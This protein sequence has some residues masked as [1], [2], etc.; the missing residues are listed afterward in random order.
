[1]TTSNDAKDANNA[2]NA[3]D[4][5]SASDASNASD[6]TGAK[7]ASGHFDPALLADLKA[8]QIAFFQ[9][10]LVSAK[11]EEDWRSRAA[12]VYAELL[13]TPLGQ[14]ADAAAIADALDAALSADAVKSAFRPLADAVLT[15]AAS[16]IRSQRARVG[17]YIPD[18]SLAKI[19]RLLERP[20]LF[21][22]RL[23]RQVVEQEAVEEVMR[24]VLYA[25]LKEFSEKV[26]PFFAEWGLPALLGKLM[27]FGF[28]GVKKALDGVRAEFDRRL[29][30]ELRKFLPGVTRRGLRQ[31]AEIMIAKSDEPNAIAAR[32]R[33]MAWILE[34][35]IR[36]LMRPLD[37]EG[38]RLAQDIG[39]DAAAHLLSLKEIRDKRRS[40][41]ETAIRER[42]SKTLGQALTEAG[43]THAPDLDA[44]ARASWPLVRSAL[45]TEAARSWIASMLEEFYE[46]VARSP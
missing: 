5:G 27:P 14:I 15:A 6:A 30:P 31:M 4:A 35:E 1:M 2:S 32:K 43:V 26:N 12:A 24:D 25:T 42:A 9:E 20:K 16:E 21:P 37:D 13:A 19:D 36:E 8:R 46:G 33:I 29:E 11:A 3:N 38:A 41:I 39:L 17:D 28:G 22:D 40:L 7:S 23:M 18:G 34:Q 44:M 45:S 10:R